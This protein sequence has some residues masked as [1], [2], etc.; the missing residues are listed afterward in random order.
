MASDG[1]IE[2]TI[3]YD[4]KNC[5]HPSPA[6]EYPFLRASEKGDELGQLA[7]FRVLR[8][9]GQGGMGVVFEAED[10]V[11]KRRVALKVIKPEIS[12]N[13][14]AKARFL[15]EARAAAL[16]EHDHVVPIYQVGEDNGVAFIVMPLLRGMNLEAR[17][18]ASPP[19]RMTELLR[20][21]VET[22]KGLAAAHAHGLIHRDVKPSNIWVEPHERSIRVK[23]LDFGLGKAIDRVSIGSADETDIVATRHTDTPP[24]HQDAVTDRP[25][26]PLH[27]EAITSAGAIV[28]TP[29]YMSPE[30]AVGKELDARSDLFS[31]GCV[32]YRM[33]AGH[34]AFRGAD[35][36]SQI[37]ATIEGQPVPLSELRPHLP[38]GLSSVVQRLLT[39]APDERQESAL[40]VVDDLTSPLAE[41]TRSEAEALLADVEEKLWQQPDLRKELYSNHDVRRGYFWLLASHPHVASAIARRKIVNLAV[42]VFAL[43]VVI[44]MLIVA[45]CLDW[46]PVPGFVVAVLCFAVTVLA[47]DRLRKMNPQSPPATPA[48]P[49][50]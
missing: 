4:R 9:L 47:R 2:E 41:A 28:G 10:P 37:E 45:Y 21:G 13:P 34:L 39:K 5:A 40:A 16:I 1:H 18:A 12:A 50:D 27:L 6:G 46:L 23:I 31:L 19:L 22:A 11:L 29:G 15:R 8:L 14:D 33:V 30:Q 38:T 25:T 17:L 49:P 24:R 26:T 43:L 35:V 48:P 3:D 7:G 36:G 44:P 42:A 32:L 20:V